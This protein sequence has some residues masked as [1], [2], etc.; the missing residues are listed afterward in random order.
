VL[1]WF[2]PVSYAA[3]LLYK[4]LGFKDYFGVAVDVLMLARV[5]RG[6]VLVERGSHARLEQIV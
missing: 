1:A 5:H 3:D 6:D 2:S 4:G